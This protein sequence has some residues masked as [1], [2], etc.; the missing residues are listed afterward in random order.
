MNHRYHPETEKY[1]PSK[2]PLRAPLRPYCQSF[3]L[4]KSGRYSRERLLEEFIA[5]PE[6]P[7]NARRR[8]TAARGDARPQFV[9]AES[10]RSTNAVFWEVP[11]D[12]LGDTSNQDSAPAFKHCQMRA[13]VQFEIR[14]AGAR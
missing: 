11:G 14:C 7:S 12:L 3:C 8:R 10:T 1:H 2:R 5:E 6:P 9:G 4:P 13:L